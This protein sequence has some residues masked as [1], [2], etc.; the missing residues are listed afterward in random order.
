ML[1]AAFHWLSVM[2]WQTFNLFYRLEEDWISMMH[3]N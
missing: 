1:S 2:L 3:E